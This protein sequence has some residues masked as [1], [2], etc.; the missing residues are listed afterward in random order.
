MADI[1]KGVTPLTTLKS[2]VNDTRVQC[3][4]KDPAADCSALQSDRVT[5]YNWAE[6][7][8]MV[9]NGDKFEGLRYWVGKTTKP[10][11]PY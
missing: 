10:D 8:A 2:Y 3:C 5:I 11:S 6:E 9:F 1:S 4:I 7:V